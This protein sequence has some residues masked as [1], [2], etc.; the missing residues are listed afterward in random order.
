MTPRIALV[1]DFHPE[2]LGASWERGLLAQGV[3]VF[4]F[5]VRHA[6]QALGLV[7][8]N[9][10]T[11]RITSQAYSIRRWAAQRYNRA[12]VDF[13]RG[14]RAPIVVFH[15]GDLVFPETVE[16]L[17]GA[18][19]RCALFHADNPLPPFANRPETLPLAQRMDDYFVWSERLVVALRGHGVAGAAF[20]P[21]AWDD[22]VFPYAPP[23]ADPWPGVLFVGG[24]D[25]EREEL[26]DELAAAVPLKIY[27]PSYWGERT[28][29]KSRARQAWTGSELRGA[30]A[31]TMI[32]ESAISLNI[33]RNQHVIEGVPDG[34]I[35]RH[36]EVP[37]AGGFLLS[38]RGGGATRLFPEGESAAY[39]SDV[40]E[41]IAQI[42]D[43]LAQPEKRRQM[44]ARAHESIRAAHTYTHR[45]AELLVSWKN[46]I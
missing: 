36:F 41:C 20:L 12:I 13:V 6:Q 5:D 40:G 9:R 14:V 27:G 17:K 34:L 16:E 33:L 46:V 43:Y 8:K 38:T 29:A 31:A 10:V 3:D 32:R 25:R 45:M 19:V 23:P 22:Q 11:R 44:I 30:P 37:G 39:F 1:A 18:G 24:W 28:R 2:R 7:L 15:N 4:P 26:L 21:F 42:R 35:M